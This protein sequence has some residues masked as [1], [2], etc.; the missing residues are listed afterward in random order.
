MENE[1]SKQKF[2]LEA[3]RNNSAF[4][5]TPLQYHIGLNMIGEKWVWETSDGPQQELGWNDW[6]DSYPVI[7]SSMTSVMNVQNG[8]SSGWQNIDPDEVM[9]GYV[10]EAKACS[11]SRFCY[12]KTSNT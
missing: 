9:A 8:A 12:I 10:C 5:Q 7:S 4:Q 11:A 1:P 3:V 2:I 6:M